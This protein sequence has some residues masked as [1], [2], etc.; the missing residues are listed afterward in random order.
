[1]V[2]PIIT[3]I[4]GILI[5]CISFFVLDGHNYKEE[6]EI[7]K[8]TSE[9][10]KLRLMELCD[11]LVEQNKTSIAE[12]SQDIKEKQE[13]ELKEELEKCADQLSEKAKKEMIDYI[14]QS[15]TE[16]FEAYNPDAEEKPEPIQYDEEVDEAQSEATMIKSVEEGPETSVSEEQPEELEDS[17]NEDV[18]DPETSEEEQSVGTDTSEEEQTVETEPSEE[19]Q[20]VEAEPSEEEQTVESEIS[21]AEQTIENDAP[22]E[23]QTTDSSVPTEQ[24][25]QDQ[26]QESSADSDK[27]VE[28]QAEKDVNE[29]KP[30]Q[31]KGKGKKKN[32]NKNK[33]KK[34][35]QNQI[36]EEI[37]VEEIWDDEKDTEAEVARLY[38]EGYG[39]MEIANQLGIGVG[40]A[41][42]I[43]NKLKNK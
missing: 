13:K 35:G 37:K 6:D 25:Q 36:K 4:V 15:L 31:K 41:K 8:E 23:E 20:T 38:E 9:E 42:V 30:V 16:A 34:Q 7:Y 17:V 27:E 40:E 11:S 10:L 26:I 28:D 43:I 21:E 29:A 14:N 1:M 2:L 3:L 24:E 22:I 39:M 18:T 32:K 19:E 12:Y 5:V 33:S